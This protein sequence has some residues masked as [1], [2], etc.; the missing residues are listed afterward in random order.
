LGLFVEGFFEKNGPSLRVD[1]TLGTI[2]EIRNLCRFLYADC[3]QDFAMRRDT[4][5]KKNK[6]IAR[7]VTK[8]ETLSKNFNENP[9]F[10]L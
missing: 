8:R 5:N 1:L 7:G 4:G 9:R 2:F 6:L 10:R 3:M